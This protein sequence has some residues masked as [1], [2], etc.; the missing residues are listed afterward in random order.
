MLNLLALEAAI[1]T[2]RK[3]EC[4]GDNRNQFD[5][6]WPIEKDLLQMLINIPIKI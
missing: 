1:K 3:T 2:L 5:F 6:E 4:F